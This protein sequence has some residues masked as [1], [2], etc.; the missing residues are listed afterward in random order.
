MFRSNTSPPS[1]ESTN[2]QNKKSTEL[3]RRYSS[4]FHPNC[5]EL[6]NP[7][8]VVHAKL[9]DSLGGEARGSKW[10]IEQHVAYPAYFRH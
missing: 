8:S 2:K 9:T 4:R 5:N 6:Y 10:H 1:S 7:C 3:R